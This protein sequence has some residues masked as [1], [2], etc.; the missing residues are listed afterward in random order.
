MTIFTELKNCNFVMA[1][2]PPPLDTFFLKE[3]FAAFLWLSNNDVFATMFKILPPARSPD[4]GKDGKRQYR[5][6]YGRQ[7]GDWR[8]RCEGPDQ[9]FFL[10]RH[11]GMGRIVFPWRGR[12]SLALIYHSSYLSSKEHERGL[13]RHVVL[14]YHQSR[15]HRFR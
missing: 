11:D 8:K 9:L 10:V 13:T 4:T 2:R 15:A 6:C 1:E 7:Q 3:S 12:R 5:R 14:L